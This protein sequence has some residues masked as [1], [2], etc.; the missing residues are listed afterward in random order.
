MSNYFEEKNLIEQRA[1]VH[2]KMKELVSKATDEKRGLTE[3]EQTQFDSWDS[4]F[5]GL[6]AK[7]EQVR[8]LN[9]R[10]EQLSDLKDKAKEDRNISPNELEDN[11]NSYTDA[12][13]KHVRGF[14]LNEEEIRLLQEQ[15]AQSTTSTAGGYTIPEGFVNNLEQ[16]R[17]S[18]GGIL[19]A[20]D[21]IYTA[22]GN[23]LPFPT[24]NDTANTGALLAENTQDSEQD[25]T[26]GVVEL[27]AYKYT[28]KIV[29]VSKELVQDSAFNMDALISENIFKERLYRILNTHFT[30]G[31]GSSKPKGVVTA[32]TNSYTAPSASAITNKD[33][34]ELEHKV[35]P[36]YRVRG[37]AK[38]GYMFSDVTFKE[39]K[40]L[41]V[42][43]SDSRP[44][45]QPSYAVG[46]PD[47]INGWRYWI[48]QDLDDVNT[49]G[50]KSILFGDFSKYKIRI[51]RD[52]TLV[53]LQE[54]Y[55]DFHQVGY[56]GFMRADG[57][58]INAGTHPIAYLTQ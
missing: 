11:V 55:A 4:E 12:F 51:V 21:T 52:Y 38:C 33:L 48:N 54:R 58:L 18:F 41:T 27:G 13:K 32:T 22:T 5:E 2:I 57:D 40:S 43:T 31:D 26:F 14:S 30:T 20:A 28:S 8:K 45:W 6:S 37:N 7:I 36:A 49:S 19:E 25:I 16:A 50:N 15:R 23:T 53:R 47:T 35:D 34:T 9:K 39:L 1:G 10:E 42:G 46:A 24:T 29:R 56:I 3:D 17:L 44:I